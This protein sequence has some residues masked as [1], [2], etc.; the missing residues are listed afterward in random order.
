MREVDSEEETVVIRSS[1]EAPQLAAFND[2]N[3]QEQ[4]PELSHLDDARSAA[5]KNKHRFRLFPDEDSP[6]KTSKGTKSFVDPPS[7]K[8]FMP[9]TKRPETSQERSQL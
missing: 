8:S 9:E 5:K 4:I 7:K 6:L 2:M 3:K 1:L